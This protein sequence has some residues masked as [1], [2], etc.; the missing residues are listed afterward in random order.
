MSAPAMTT[1]GFPNL[2][3]SEW[4]KLRSVR[5]TAWCLAI[6]AV[7]MI[8]L[9]V[10]MGVRWAD[11][12]A[13][14]S[15]DKRSGFDPTNTT[16]AGVYIAQIVL[17]ALGVLVISGEYGTG[18]IRA[19]L[20]AVPQ[21]RL[22]L[23]AKMLVVAATALVVG[24]VLSFAAFG[25]GQALLDRRGFGT[26]LSAPGVLRAVA[27]AG[28]NLTGITLLA[29]GLGALLRHAAAALSTLFGVL[30]ALPALSDLLPTSW[31]NHVI[32]YLPLNAGSQIFVTVPAHGA[33]SPWHGLLVLCCY[34][35]VVLV[36]A[37]VLVE[38]RD[39]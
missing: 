3:R 21:R 34:P 20:A 14:E 7:A 23:A 26:S 36:L 32:N 11:V 17:G 37:F 33:L 2:L 4:T 8:G 1:V 39:A 18:L 16:L 27:G 9:A 28:L 10:L 19:S 12:L 6:V 38:R 24:E 5:S 15:A 30:F 22:F 29:F 31:R 13:A 25:I 35:L